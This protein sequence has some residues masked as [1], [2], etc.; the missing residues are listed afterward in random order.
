MNRTAKFG[1]SSI[2]TSDSGKLSVWIHSDGRKTTVLAAVVQ[3]RF[4]RL[5]LFIPQFSRVHLRHYCMVCLYNFYRCV[6]IISIIVLLS[7]HC[8]L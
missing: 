4:Q 7:M 8:C 2:K 1:V 5:M 6:N 3:L